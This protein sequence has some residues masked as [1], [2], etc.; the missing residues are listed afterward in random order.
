VNASVKRITTEAEARAAITI[1]D[2]CGDKI[3][4]GHGGKKWVP[5]WEVRTP[6][7]WCF[8]PDRHTSVCT[9]MAQA[10]REAKKEPI[11]TCKPD[12]EVCG[13]GR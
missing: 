9:S 5:D 13:V 3:D 2:G 1:E 6:D 7:G 4:D 12:C 11:Y 8:E 10:R